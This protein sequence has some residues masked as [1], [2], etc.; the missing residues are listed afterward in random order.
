MDPTLLEPLKDLGVPGV[1]I[2]V[3]GWAYWKERE[4]NNDLV[5]K[6]IAESRESIAA[7]KD[8]TA[9]IDALAEVV[10]A[11]RNGG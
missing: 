6:R 11:Q 9:A 2:L 5:E 7:M 3:L 4:R 10:K 1:I 8:N